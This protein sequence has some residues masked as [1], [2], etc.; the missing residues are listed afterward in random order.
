MRAAMSQAGRVCRALPEL[1]MPPKV[2]AS[3]ADW[4]TGH[5][6]EPQEL[7]RTCCGGRP[8]AGCPGPG[9]QGSTAGPLAGQGSAPEPPACGARCAATAA[10]RSCSQWH[11]AFRCV[12]G[13][14]DTARQRLDSV[15]AC[16]CREG[17]A[18]CARQ[19]TE[20][21]AHWRPRR[22]EPE[23]M[24]WQWRMGDR[25]GGDSRPA[26]LRLLPLRLAELPLAELPPR[27]PSCRVLA[28][29]WTS[30]FSFE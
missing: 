3:C 15:L 11:H 28:P 1:P 20:G 13:D 17:C 25:K 26:L 12:P 27:L 8:G 21:A 14:A 30:I 16:A 6:V 19:V 5:A 24:L 23:G 9:L 29:S 10:P 2:P 18:R 22:R 4:G 7:G